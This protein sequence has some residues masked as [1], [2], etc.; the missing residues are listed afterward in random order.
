MAALATAGR[1]VVRLL[2][3]ST[4]GLLRLLSVHQRNQ[5]GVT[6]DEI[7]IMLEQG[8]EEGVFEPAERE[9]V[10]NVLNLDE[11]HVGGVLT[12]RSAI[13]VLDLR[14]MDVNREKRRAN[15]IDAHR[16]TC[17]RTPEVMSGTV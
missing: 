12:P 13:V 6:V 2:S 15:R 16:G 17:R 11:R 7:R 3:V 14:A 9:M 5:L 8:A 4:D 10:T 1:P